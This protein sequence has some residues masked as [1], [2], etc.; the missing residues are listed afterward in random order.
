M[1][2]LTDRVAVVTGASRGI[3]AGLVRAFR[4][5]GLRVAL[6]A[7]SEP[8]ADE[9]PPGDDGV[10]FAPV[11]VSDFGAV[12]AF[13]REAAERFGAPDLW[14]NNAG[15]LDPIGPLRAVEPEAFSR[16][17]RVNIDGVFHGTRAALD[18]W[19][20]SG[21]TGTVVNISSGAATSA[22]EG[23]GAYC[24]TKA[25]VEMLTH[26]TALEEGPRGHRVHALAPGVVA[27]DMQALIRAQ[28]EGLFPNVE[29]FRGMHAEGKLADPESPAPAILRLAFGAPVDAVSL[30]VRSADALGDL[31]S[32]S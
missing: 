16:Q 1:T 22:Y 20:R 24:A 32:Y 26:V 5:K 7:R 6:C 14:V 4:R 2:D 31:S 30:D 17:M 9:V 12:A 25:A 18:V 8:S 19:E 11:D 13:A 29:R 3:G 27:T 21:H 23:W 15:I 10:W 28:D